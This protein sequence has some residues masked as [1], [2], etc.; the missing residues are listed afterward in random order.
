M[1]AKLESEWLVVMEMGV[2]FAIYFHFISSSF[3]ILE[4]IFLVMILFL[5]QVHGP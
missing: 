1:V 3:A 5:L 2:A 4:M